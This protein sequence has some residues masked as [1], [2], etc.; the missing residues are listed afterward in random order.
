M[1]SL[2]L[3]S[4]NEKDARGLLVHEL[5]ASSIPKDEVLANL[6]L[7][8]TPQNLSRILFFNEIYKKI[9]DKHGVIMEFGCKWGNSLA[10]LSALRDIYEP[11]NRHR[12]IIGFDT[13][14]GFKGVSEWDKGVSDGDFSTG[15]YQP[16]LERILDLHQSMDA[17][18]HIKKYEIVGGDVCET[19]A[20]YLAEHDE[21]IVSLA[22]FDMDIYKPTASALSTLSDGF[23]PKGSIMV[24]DELCDEIFPGET[25]ALDETFSIGSLEINRLPI[26]SRMSYVVVP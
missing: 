2:T 4:Q 17:L 18:P 3:S 6:G 13:F 14:S 22:I 25:I 26:T 5:Y 8:T 24:F 21:T 11:R 15:D 16:T 10:I 19:L 20:D 1:K 12:K 9:L 7:Y 23:L